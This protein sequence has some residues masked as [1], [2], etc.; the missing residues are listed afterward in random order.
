MPNRIGYQPA[1]S[2]C[3]LPQPGSNNRSY[4]PIQ[5]MLQFILS[6]WCGTNRLNDFEQHDMHYLIGGIRQITDERK[7]AKGRQLS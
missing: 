2:A 1:V 6:V 7:N 3:E 4:A 5:L